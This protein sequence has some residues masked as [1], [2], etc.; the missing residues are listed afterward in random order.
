MNCNHSLLGSIAVLILAPGL[1]GA[2]VTYLNGTTGTTTEVNSASEMAYQ[3]DASNSDL[4]NNVSPTLVTTGNTLG[5]WNTSNGATVP[6]LN[7]GIHGV[8]FAAAGSSVEGA[9]PNGGATATYNLGLGANNLGFDITSVQSLAAWVNASFGNQAW[10][11]AVQPAGGGAFRDIA[12]VDYQPLPGGTSIGATKV[13]L[14]GLNI[15][16]IQSVRVTTIVLN[17]GNSGGA[18]VWRELDVFGAP[19]VVPEPSATLLLS[20]GGLALLRRRR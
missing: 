15:T 3:A 14:T 12:T 2:A 19:T 10:T 4:L 5:T 20:L 7:D 1:A 16:G 11:M 17:G 13:S 6:E 18:F 9:F 8:T